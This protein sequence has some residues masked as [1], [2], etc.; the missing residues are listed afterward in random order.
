MTDLRPCPSC[1]SHDATPWDDYSPAPWVVARCGAC[2]LTYLRNPVDYVALEEDF[3]W[4][5]TYEEKKEVS[6]GSTSLSPAIRGLRK[7]LKLTHKSKQHRMGQWFNNGKVLDIGCGNLMNVPEPMTPYGIELSKALHAYADD[8]M[9]ARGGYCVHGAGAEAIWDFEPDMFDGV[10]MH[11]YLEHEVD[12][13]GVLKGVWRALKP[14][15]P[16]YVRVPNFG[17]INRKVVGTN[18]CGFRYP[19]HV[20]YFTLA[21]LRDVARRAGFTVELVNRVGLPIDDNIKA[22]LR[23][24]PAPS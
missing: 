8:W 9:Q 11:S 14:G 2:D 20:T 3:A 23:K 22:L 12:L 17:S 4:E 24:G 16:A 10:I 15:A 7:R 21:S 18:W 5:K 1:T 13:M 6:T 19:D